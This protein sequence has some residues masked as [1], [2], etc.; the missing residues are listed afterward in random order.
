MK[1]GEFNMQ[2]QKKLSKFLQ[3]NRKFWTGTLKNY[4]C[5]PPSKKTFIVEVRNV[6]KSYI[7][8]F[9]SDLH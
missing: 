3:P 6:Y 7:E 1:G 5:P 2:P 9:A 4:H 8:H